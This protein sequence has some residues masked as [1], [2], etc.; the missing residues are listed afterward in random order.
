MD[1]DA[2]TGPSE[3]VEWDDEVTSLGRRMRRGS[4]DRWIVQ[5]RVRGKMRKKVIG[6]GSRLSADEARRAA[7]IAMEHMRLGAPVGD[8][9][10]PPSP[11][12]RI[13]EFGERF[14]RDMAP[15]WKSKTQKGHR[16][17]VERYIN[18][19]LGSTR[20]AELTQLGVQTWRESFDLKASTI[21]LVMAVLSGMMRHAEVLGVRPP[22]SNPCKGLRRR[23]S[24]FSAQYLSATGYRSLARALRAFERERPVE[25]AL[26]RFLALTGC[27]RSEALKMEWEWVTQEAVNLPDSKTG[28]RSIWLGEASR[29][30]L[31]Q[32]ERQ[33]RYVFAVNGSHLKNDRLTIFWDKVRTKMDRPSLRI[34]DLR[35]SFASTGLNHG[36]DLGTIGGLLGHAHKS[37]TKG[38]AHLAIAP[39]KEAANRVG[40]M[41][42]V[43]SSLTPPSK[44]KARA[45][46]AKTIKAPAVAKP[47]DPFPDVTRFQKAGVSIQ[48]YCE[49]N[50]M[51]LDELRRRIK[52][53]RRAQGGSL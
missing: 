48:R 29:A 53:W 5:F 12:V 49:M 30:V 39:V 52:K 42:A 33:G 15:R 14:L 2:K 22:G 13:S 47:A 3:H 43:K 46:K 20:V 10:Q 27:R 36:E 38:Y 21:N 34:H 9:S 45:P 23:K 1:L 8:L 51:D 17:C 26:I 40:E 50:G 16:L 18:P 28:P 41:L 25:I 24:D 32:I 31:G 35:H 37:A 6:D 7:I 19:S 11:M 44:T 4:P